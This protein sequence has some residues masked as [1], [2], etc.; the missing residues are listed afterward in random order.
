MPLHIWILRQSELKL[1][2]CVSS[3]TSRPRQGGYHILAVGG[4]VGVKVMEWCADC[5]EVEVDWRF[6]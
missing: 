3:W 5:R 1:L 4:G 2:R 6:E